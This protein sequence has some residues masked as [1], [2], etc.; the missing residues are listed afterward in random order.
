MRYR[1]LVADEGDASVPNVHD[2]FT[3]KRVLAMERAFGRPIEELR[4]PDCSQ[5]LRDELGTL[6]QKLVFRE[7]FEFR[8]MQTDPN[9]ANYLFDPDSRRLILLDFGS[10][11]EF[12]AEFVELYKRICR[13]MIA[14][15]HE[16][17]RR[18]AVAIGYLSGSESEGRAKGLV[19]LISMVGEPI[20]HRG[21]YDFEESGLASR[22]R[23]AGFDLVFREGFMRA[24]PPE[25]IF[26]HRKLAGTFFLCSHIRA[27]VDTRALIAPYLEND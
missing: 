16:E 9:F 23:D 18:A 17:I 6:L 10:A 11:R 26:L 5:S 13:G 1:K 3:T 19:D 20:R 14:Q 8:F 24:P 4:S 27:R 22:A 21:V 25:T 2:D 7:L 15:D 12:P